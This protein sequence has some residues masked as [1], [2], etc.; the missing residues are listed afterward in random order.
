M[1]RTLHVNIWGWRGIGISA[2]G[3]GPSWGS[4]GHAMLSDPAT[5]TALLSQ[6][7]HRR[8]EVSAAH[9][10]NILMTYRDTIE[11]EG[12]SADVTYE[13][14]IQ[15]GCLADLDRAVAIEV[16]C[17]FWDWDPMPPM[18]THCARA[19]YEALV[20]SGID[21]DPHNRFT[22]KPGDRR[23]LLPNMLWY[24]LSLYCPHPFHQQ[25]PNLDLKTIEDN[26]R[27]VTLVRSQ[28]LWT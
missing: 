12:R 7:P 6:F 24:L 5:N 20:A 17:P 28:K 27:V 21:I 8:G 1:A 3:L 26:Q 10:P 13:V 14:T 16:A 9:G 11:E 2:P 18:Q 22:S 4:V 23:Q 25:V 19:V 15:D